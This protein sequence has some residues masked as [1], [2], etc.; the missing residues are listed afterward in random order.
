MLL[1]PIYAS[2]PILNASSI[3]PND[4]IKAPTVCGT[5]NYTRQAKS[6]QPHNPLSA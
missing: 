5:P 3:S 1:S 4:E 2:F 6:C